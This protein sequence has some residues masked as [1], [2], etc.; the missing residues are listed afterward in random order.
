MYS[1]IVSLLQF[2]TAPLPRGSHDWSAATWQD[3]LLSG[4]LPHP[5]Y[6]LLVAPGIQDRV[7]GDLR[8]LDPRTLTENLHPPVIFDEIQKM[9]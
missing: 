5:K 4:P 2:R 6:I 8:S 7:R 9:G 1:Q 3:S